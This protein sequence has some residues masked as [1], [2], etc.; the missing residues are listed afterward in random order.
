MGRIGV[1]RQGRSAEGDPRECADPADRPGVVAVSGI[2][3]V[4]SEWS[5]GRWPSALY[6]LA[7]FAR[8]LT[9]GK[10][11]RGSPGLSGKPR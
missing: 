2:A 9:L 6:P 3:T 5:V 11:Q 4:G 7:G 10:R 8:R 1:L